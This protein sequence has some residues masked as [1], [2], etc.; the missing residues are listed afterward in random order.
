MRFLVWIIKI[1][2]L[3][4]FVW[5][6]V[7]HFRVLRLL[8]CLRFTLRGYWLGGLGFLRCIRCS[9]L[10]S[11]PSCSWCTINDAL[12]RISFGR[13]F[14]S[15]EGLCTRLGWPCHLCSFG[16][17]RTYLQLLLLRLC[18]IL[19]SRCL[20][21]FALEFNQLLQILK[22]LINSIIRNLSYLLIAIIDHELSAYPG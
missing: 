21:H 16:R 10:I 6:W 5:G 12:F 17:I 9:N 20:A 13:T 11:L 18:S 15:P 19:L 7:C 2:L 14:I 8:I 4:Q 1:L 3:Q 22:V